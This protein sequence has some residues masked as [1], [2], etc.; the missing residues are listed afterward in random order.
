MSNVQVTRDVEGERSLPVFQEISDR[1][2]AVR[3]KAFAL[4]QGRGGAIGRDMD[5]WIAAERDVMGWP[6][7][8]LTEKQDAF[9]VEVTLPGF[10]VQEVEVTATPR[11][12]VVHAA[13]QHEAKGEE[14][15]V[16]WSEY[17]SNDVY[18]S[19]ELPTPVNADKVTARL[20]SGILHVI[21]PK[22]DGAGGRQVPVTAA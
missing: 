18:R 21:A 22:S 14:A 1:L 13:C 17:G 3:Q 2:E 20:D 8:Q 19:F 6:A 7:A 16:V 12:I 11:E 10:A 5:D 4:F 15:K 9:E